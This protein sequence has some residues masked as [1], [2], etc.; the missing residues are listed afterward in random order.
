LK[1]NISVTVPTAR[2]T[3]I[4]VPGNSTANSRIMGPH[5]SKVLR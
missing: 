2:N 4:A 1:P 5:V 3:R